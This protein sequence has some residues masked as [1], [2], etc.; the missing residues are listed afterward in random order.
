[1][2]VLIMSMNDYI[3]DVSGPYVCIN[4]YEW[5]PETRSTASG[6]RQS[7]INDISNCIIECRYNTSCLALDFNFQNDRCFWYY[8]NDYLDSITGNNN[9]DQYRKCGAILGEYISRLYLSY[10]IP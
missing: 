1:M 2:C 8:D 9:Y 7:D 4:D 10:L 6:D 5:Y 3:C